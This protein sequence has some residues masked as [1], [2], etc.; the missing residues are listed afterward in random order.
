MTVDTV[1]DQLRSMAL[2]MN[3]LGATKEDLLA[4]LPLIGVAHDPDSGALCVIGTDGP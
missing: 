4:L 1:L 2:A 3:E